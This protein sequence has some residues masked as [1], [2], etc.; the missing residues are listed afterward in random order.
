MSEP[1]FP[2]IKHLPTTEQVPFREW[3]RGRQ[4]P[5]GPGHKEMNR[6]EWDWYY[7]HDYMMWKANQQ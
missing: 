4:Q 7:P 3:L 1:D 6:S 5:L 2:R